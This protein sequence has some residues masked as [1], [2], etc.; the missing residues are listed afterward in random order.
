MALWPCG[1][2][3]LSTSLRRS[4][5][6]QLAWVPRGAPCVESQCRRNYS[7]PRWR[8]LHGGTRT[9]LHPVSLAS[10]LPFMTPAEIRQEIIDILDD[11]SPDEDLD[12]LDDQ[13]AF[14]EQLELD[15]MDFLDIVMELRKRHRVQIPEEDYGHLASMHTTVTYLEPKMK[16]L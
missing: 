4:V 1:S 13:K 16:D 12:N 14:R 7:I 10:L 8:L 5:P 9:F 2:E 11:I 15:S 3:P 6:I